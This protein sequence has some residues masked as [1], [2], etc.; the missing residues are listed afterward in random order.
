MIVKPFHTKQNAFTY[1]F[2]IKL[3]GVKIVVAGTSNQAFL[4]EG[5]RCNQFWAASQAAFSAAR[6]RGVAGKTF[7]VPMRARAPL[8]CNIVIA[9]GHD[10]GRQPFSLR[11][12]SVC[13]PEC[14]HRYA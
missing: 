8:F 10:V 13:H 7:S 14:A 3:I 6:M 1:K 4:Y 11:F 2:I 5:E 9:A 12:C